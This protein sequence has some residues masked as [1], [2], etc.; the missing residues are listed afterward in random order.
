MT[1]DFRRLE[2]HSC[3]SDA[4]VRQQDREEMQLFSLLQ[5]ITYQ[6]VKGTNGIF[7]ISLEWLSSEIAVGLN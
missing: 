1:K 3:I 7:C 5:K 2:S 4:I 6:Q